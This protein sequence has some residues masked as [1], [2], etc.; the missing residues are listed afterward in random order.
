MPD[1][2]VG[3]L[4]CYDWNLKFCRGYYYLEVRILQSCGWF[5]VILSSSDWL[6]GILPRF[7]WLFVILQSYG[8][9]CEYWNTCISS[10]WLVGWK[11]CP[12]SL[13]SLFESSFLS[14][15]RRSCCGFLIGGS[16][17]HSVLA[18]I[19]FLPV[20]LNWLNSVSCKR[21]SFMPIALF[22][23]VGDNRSQAWLALLWANQNDGL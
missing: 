18:V 3:I 13:V 12:G 6:V 2:W 23:L 20:L 21:L 22:W 1:G 14:C 10:W 8:L 17:Q 7:D 15:R 19:F 5:V 16:V 11:P 4:Y 9:F